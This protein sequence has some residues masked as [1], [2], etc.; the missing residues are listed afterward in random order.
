MALCA[1][2]KRFSGYGVGVLIQRRGFIDVPA[3]S[4]ADKTSRSQRFFASPLAA[5]VPGTLALALVLAA[6]GGTTGT[7]EGEESG[8]EGGESASASEVAGDNGSSDTAV[9]TAGGPSMDADG[10]LT[11]GLNDPYVPQS[12]TGATDDYRCF[13]VDLG[14]DEDRMVT[15]VR[16]TPGNPDV[17]HHAILYRVAPD[18]VAAAV[19]RDAR[20]EGQ[21]WSCF[22][23]TDL[24]PPNE[25]ADTLTA[26]QGSAWL[27][28]WA[29]GGRETRYAEGTAVQVRAGSKAVLQVHYNLLAG[30]GPDLTTVHLRTVPD[31]GS[32]KP[33]QTYLLPGPVEIPCA[34]DEV[35]PLCDREASVAD[36]IARFGGESLRTIWGLQF[37][38]GGD[39]TEPKAGATQTCDHRAR[40][41]MVVH[42]AAGHMHL[43]GRSL[44]IVSNPGTDREE[45]LIDIPAWDF[46]DQ[47]AR[48][49]PKPVRI[50]TD[51]VLRVTCTHDVSLRRS[52]PALQGVEPRYV[53]WGEGTTDEM[54][55]GLLSVTAG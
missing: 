26:I 51:D 1:T 42:A 36:T 8:S 53:T 31:D 10:I 44:T 22:G 40:K 9:S 21:G 35:G 33:L 49:L 7:S 4:P 37:I 17:V 12:T 52:L 32:L 6:C 15:G 11:V 34:D 54:C 14:L 16:F 50:E 5:V 30:Q 25:S 20:D 46:D 23:G 29:P 19:E 28:A 38:C 47:S 48:P 55:L 2:C 45:L 27:A 18:Q 24:P 13:L 39:L 3:V 43:L 41:P